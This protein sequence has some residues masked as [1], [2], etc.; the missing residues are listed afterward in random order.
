MVMTASVTGGAERTGRQVE[1]VGAGMEV[2]TG[3][4]VIG[5]PALETERWKTFLYIHSFVVHIYTRITN[6]GI[7]G[8][9]AC[10]VTI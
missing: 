9:C 7:T 5:A 3:V 4:V 10:N 6:G 2:V 1:R 8:L